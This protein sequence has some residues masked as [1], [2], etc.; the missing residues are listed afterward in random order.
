MSWTLL[1]RN[2]KQCGNFNNNNNTTT[3]ASKKVQRVWIIVNASKNLQYDRGN[4][5]YNIILAGVGF[6]SKYFL[7]R[8]SLTP[9]GRRVFTYIIILFCRYYSVYLS[10]STRL[11][12]YTPCSDMSAGVIQRR[13][14]IIRKGLI[15]KLSLRMT[16]IKTVNTT[17]KDGPIVYNYV[18]KGPLYHH[19]SL[20]LWQIIIYIKMFVFTQQ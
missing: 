11:F 9:I 5:I 1:K 10:I 3:G 14:Y 7:I 20:S 8:C 2:G 4:F 15:N 6:F 17:P 13:L 18:P 12:D 16:I 19:N